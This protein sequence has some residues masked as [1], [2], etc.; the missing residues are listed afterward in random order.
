MHGGAV[1]GFLGA[2]EAPY[3]LRALEAADA[4]EAIGAA[5]AALLA[6][7]ETVV[8]DSGT[9]ALHVVVCSARGR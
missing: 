7:G 6:D 2:E 8:L 4:K 5:A 9:T 3:G 1:R